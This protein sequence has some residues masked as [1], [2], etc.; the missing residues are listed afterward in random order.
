MHV[1]HASCMLALNAVSDLKC[2][3]YVADQI[4]L[5]QAK[6][7]SQRGS[8]SVLQW[9]VARLDHVMTSLGSRAKKSIICTYTPD[10]VTYTTLIYLFILFLVSCVLWVWSFRIQRDC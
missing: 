2:A 5:D 4:Y 1:L 10:Y 9:A 8:T 6:Q 3:F 7:R